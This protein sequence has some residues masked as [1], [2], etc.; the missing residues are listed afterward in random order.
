[1]LSLWMKYCELWESHPPKWKNWSA[2]RKVLLEAW[3]GLRCS[4]L[5]QRKLCGCASTLNRFLVAPLFH[6]LIGKRVS[7]PRSASTSLSSSQWSWHSEWS[8]GIDF[9]PLFFSVRLSLWGPHS[10]FLCTW[11]VW[12]VQQEESLFEAA[13]SRWSPHPSH[14]DS[15]LLDV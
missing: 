5:C 9:V 7:T 12:P 15:N 10:W 1:M 13:Y 11:N 3:E 2:Q 4:C 8:W 6:Y 14:F